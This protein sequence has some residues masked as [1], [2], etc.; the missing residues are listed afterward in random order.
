MYM[1]VTLCIIVILYHIE[2]NLSEHL[3]LANHSHLVMVRFLF[4]D[5]NDQ[6]YRCTCLKFKLVIIYLVTFETFPVLYSRETLV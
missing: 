3:N 1:N 4:H 6:H 5:L 2:G